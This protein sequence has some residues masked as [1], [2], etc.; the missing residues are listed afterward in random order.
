M[1]GQTPPLEPESEEALDRN[2]RPYYAIT[3]APG[4]HTQVWGNSPDQWLRARLELIFN[5]QILEVDSAYRSRVVLRSQ[6]RHVTNPRDVL[7]WL[8]DHRPRCH[9]RG[10]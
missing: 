2:V 4:K 5:R 10:L 7:Q 9:S 8:G 3:A 1:G 6:I